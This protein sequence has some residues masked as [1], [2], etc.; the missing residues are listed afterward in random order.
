MA[1]AE[2][3]YRNVFSRFLAKGFLYVFIIFIWFETI[4][5]ELLPASGNSSTQLALQQN[6]LTTK[7]QDLW[8]FVVIKEVYFQ[9]AK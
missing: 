2:G 8:Q 7:K 3:M 1:L 4:I 9:K 5:L 6:F